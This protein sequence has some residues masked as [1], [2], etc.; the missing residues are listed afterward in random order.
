MPRM[1]GLEFARA[2]RAMGAAAPIVLYT[3]YD[4]GL[5]S[6][7]VERAGVAALVRKPIDPH[8]LLAVL[9]K[10]LRRSMSAH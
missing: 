1:T 9:Q 6:A 5:T 7:A 8:L 10:H 4:E 2:A 3:G